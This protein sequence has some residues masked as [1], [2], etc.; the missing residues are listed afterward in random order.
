MSSKSKKTITE[1]QAKELAKNAEEVKLSEEEVEL[2]LG[3]QRWLR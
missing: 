1:S 3:R 2:N